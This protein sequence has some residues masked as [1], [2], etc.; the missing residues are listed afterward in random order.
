MCKIGTNFLCPHDKIELTN[1][2]APDRAQ[3]SVRYPKKIIG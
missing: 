2:E 1:E 3:E